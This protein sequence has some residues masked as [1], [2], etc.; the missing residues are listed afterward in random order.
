MTE[1]GPK[2]VSR[3][4][5]AAVGPVS[6]LGLFSGR[7][8]HVIIERAETEGVTLCR[9]GASVSALTAC[10]SAETSWTGLPRGVPVRNTTLAGGGAVFAT[11]EHLMSAL[12][13]L[14]VW[15]AAVR[16]EAGD[17][18]PILDGSALPWV[19]AL[20]S[21][22]VPGSAIEPI[23][24]RERIEV[25]QGHASIVATPRACG[26]SHTY[27]LDYGVG[28]P[29][30]AQRATWEGCPRAYE[31]EIAPARTFSLRREAEAARA[32]GLF[33]HLTPREMIVVGDDGEPID[34]AWRTANEPA[35]HKLLDLIGDLAL[36]GR[37][38]QADVVATRSG[39][40]LTHEFC[41]R[42]LAGG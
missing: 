13:G 28:S 38:L 17:E 41:R 30:P 5:S 21:A 24:P 15:S 7:P 19:A 9:A 26:L 37:P 29:I 25:V 4:L 2:G 8:A 12:A 34:N 33:S 18:A 3:G 31:A 35:A 10:V 1:P 20:R 14:G 16:F 22:L 27:V 32:M 42:V 6:G 11:V 39:H 40:G 23:V 36:L